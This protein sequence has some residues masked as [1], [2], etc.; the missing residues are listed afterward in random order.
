MSQDEIIY[1]I[2]HATSGKDSRFGKGGPWYKMTFS[3]YVKKAVEDRYYALANK[4][5]SH[6]VNPGFGI[7][8]RGMPIGGAAAT[9]RD[10]HERAIA[11]AF[12][13]GAGAADKSMEDALI[14]EAM[15]QHFLTDAFAA[16]HV[17]TRRGKIEKDWDARY[18]DFPYQIINR[19]VL[20]MAD[21]LVRTGENLGYYLPQ[22]KVEA[23]VRKTINEKL[24]TKGQLT[25][26]KFIGLVAHDYDNE[27]GL[28][29]VNHV[30]QHW[31][32]YGDGNLDRQPMGPFQKGEN[33]LSHR[34]I[35][36]M[37]VKAGVDDIR[38]AYSLGKTGKKL[39]FPDL[40]QAVRDQSASPAFPS[41]LYAPEMYMPELDPAK[42]Q[43]QIIDSDSI[44]NLFETR[45]HRNG[46]SYKKLIED[47]VRSGTIHD[48]LQDISQDLPAN[49]DAL[50]GAATLHPKEAFEN[51]VIRPLQHDP[52]LYLIYVM[53]TAPPGS[54]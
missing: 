41:A 37:A 34:Q 38:N 29:F 8:G 12:G 46:P 30:G 17:S 7:D 49:Q 35:I 6:F 26:G 48:E 52:T 18:P 10:A 51:A 42:D 32:G 20:D 5:Y 1:A 39:S 16:G 33:P 11:V 9:Y 25:L 24:A 3:P 23:E 4:N 53:R 21:Y 22:K 14:T 50:G 43:E 45:I 31:F 47:S 2:Y 40:S 54:F 15:G 28:W 27:N 36:A 44:E 19:I 13:A